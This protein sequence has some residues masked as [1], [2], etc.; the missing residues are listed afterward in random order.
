M[1]DWWKN[2]KGEITKMLKDT[3]QDINKFFNYNDKYIL[4]FIYFLIQVISYKLMTQEE[5]K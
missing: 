3:N 5:V 1:E 4:S 2:L